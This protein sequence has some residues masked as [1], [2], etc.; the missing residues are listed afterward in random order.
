M[1]DMCENGIPWASKYGRGELA[2]AR[3]MLPLTQIFHGLSL[4]HLVSDF[5]WPPSD[6]AI[7]Q[8]P[9]GRLLDAGTIDPRITVQLA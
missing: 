1:K 8:A 5:N 6:E 4:K 2:G 3:I 9:H 7:M